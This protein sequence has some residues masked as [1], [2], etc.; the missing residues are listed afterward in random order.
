[1]ETTLLIMAA[2]NVYSTRSQVLE[3]ERLLSLH[4]RERNIIIMAALMGVIPGCT[5]GAAA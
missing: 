3:F 2:Q 5:L 1:M 4:P